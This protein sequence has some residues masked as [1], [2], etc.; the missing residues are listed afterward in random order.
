MGFHRGDPAVSLVILV[1]SSTSTIM[2]QVER[3][4]KR[5]GPVL[6]VDGV[7]LSLA[8]GEVHALLGPNGAG[9]TTLVR[10]LVGL[11]MPDEGRIEWR[12]GRPSLGYLPEDRGL[13]RDRRVLDILG[14]FGRLYGLPRREAQSRAQRWLERLG[15][16]DRGRAKLQELSKG[17]QQKVQLAAALLHE[18]ALAVLD[19]PFSGLDPINQE[20][21]VELVGE[22]RQQGTTVLLSAHQ[23]DLVERLADRI[24]L[25]SR[26]RVALEGTLPE[27]RAAAAGGERHR[28]RF[29]SAPP[30][31]P[32]RVHPAVAAV[33]VEPADARALELELRPSHALGEVLATMPGVAD[34]RAVE[35]RVV[36]LHEIYL[37]AVARAAADVAPSRASASSPVAEAAE[38]ERAA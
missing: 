4:T 23:M 11:A 12:S 16:G 5:W 10:M 13:Y 33:H 35:R 32:L 15:L 1:L 17:N 21:V 30:L 14:F 36:G 28:L 20:L 24:T 19:E 18:P 6:A 27:L 31:E 22:L 26:G 37:N 7:S 34:L 29:G 38:K 2:L 8:T 25:V 3:V 9:K